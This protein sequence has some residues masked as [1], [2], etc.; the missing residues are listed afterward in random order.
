MKPRKLR[1][2]LEVTTDLPL[3]DCMHPAYWQRAIRLKEACDRTSSIKSIDVH[4]AL[5]VRGRKRLPKNGRD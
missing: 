3:E 2:T 5:A 1:I 4:N